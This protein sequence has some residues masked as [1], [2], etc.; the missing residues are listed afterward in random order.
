MTDHTQVK[1]YN[2]TQLGS[3]DETVGLRTGSTRGHDFC[4]DLTSSVGTMMPSHSEIMGEGNSL[5]SRSSADLLWTNPDLDSAARG[6]MTQWVFFF[7]SELSKSD[8]LHYFRNE[9]RLQW[10]IDTI[11][12]G[13]G[14]LWFCINDVAA[15]FQLPL[16]VCARK[17][18]YDSDVI[19][20]D[21]SLSVLIVNSWFNSHANPRA[22]TVQLMLILISCLDGQNVLEI[23]TD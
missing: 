12:A 20:T 19:R 15:D 5:T 9:I 10:D 4:H 13:S 1:G 14:L 23:H 2:V 11:T 17:L 3:T 7:P 6:W 18:K 21:T 16:R 22:V 8:L